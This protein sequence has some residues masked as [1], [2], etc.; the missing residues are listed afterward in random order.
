[1]RSMFVLIFSIPF[2]RE[3]PDRA[4]AATRGED[5]LARVGPFRPV[6]KKK[7]ESKKLLLC[8]IHARVA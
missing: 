5:S 1:M 7:R 6:S 8:L 2:H 4:S 3:L